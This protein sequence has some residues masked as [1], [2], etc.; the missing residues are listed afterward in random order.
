MF[1]ASEILEL[2][3][4]TPVCGGCSQPKDWCM[5]EELDYFDG[6]PP[7]GEQHILESGFSLLQ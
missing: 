6:S 7:E 3:D 2:F 1:D 4:D 5:C